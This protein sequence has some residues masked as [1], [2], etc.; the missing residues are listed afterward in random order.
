LNLFEQAAGIAAGG[1]IP[2]PE[3]SIPADETLEPFGRGRSLWVL[4]KKA[5]YRFSLDAVLLAGLTNLRSGDRV[6]DLGAGCGIVSLILACRFP[7]CSFIGIEKQPSLASLA[8]RNV[9]LNGLAGQIHIKIKDMQKLRGYF[10]PQSFSAVVSNPPYRPL[11]SGRLNPTAEKAG[12]RHELHGSLES[13]AG[14]AD[15]LLPAGGRLAIIYPAWRL[16]HLC[17]VLRSFRLEPK[18]MCLIHSRPGEEAKLVWVEARKAGGEELKILPPLMV[19][20]SQ[21]G[22]SAEMEELF[23]F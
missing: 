1:M 4:Q 19:Y 15:Y 5:G 20:A 11:G 22:Y 10:P 6:A 9:L 2:K 8:E 3:E 13:V 16:T 21:G 23:S 14:T 12:A 7:H 17:R 18:T